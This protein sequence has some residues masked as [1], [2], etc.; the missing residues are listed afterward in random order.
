MSY[1]LPI[2]RFQLCDV[3]AGKL[4]TDE[5][6]SQQVNK[7]RLPSSLADTSFNS[8]AELGPSGQAARQ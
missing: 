2:G 6:I 8:L 5:V 7:L 4:Q 1:M 3:I